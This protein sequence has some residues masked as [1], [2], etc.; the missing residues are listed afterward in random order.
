MPDIICVNNQAG[1]GGI[2]GGQGSQGQASQSASGAGVNS[3]G[4]PVL[5]ITTGM[6]ASFDIQLTQDLQGI[7][8]SDLT[9]IQSIKMVAKPSMQ[10]SNITFQK[11]CT[12]TDATQGK[13]S[14]QLTPTQVN[15]N[16]G[17]HFAQILCYNADQQQ[18]KNYRCYVEIRKGMIGARDQVTYPVTVLDVRLA[19]MDTCA[20]ANHLLDDLEF[21]DMMIID[22]VQRAV[23][24]WNET[25]P[26]ISVM[27]TASNFPWRQ[28]LIKGAVGYLM[29]MVAYRYNRNRMQYS[30][31]GINLDDSD[32]GPNYIAMAQ[33]AK[34][35]W[36]LW[37]MTKKTQCNMQQCFGVLSDP[38]FRNYSPWYS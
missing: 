18:V 37:L 22:S 17:L 19:I 24:Q 34:Q 15:Y 2:A 30:N 8:P 4:Y 23:N 27:Y 3:N 26:Q 21:S 12:I 11:D 25:P 32:K 38:T 6:T 28:H 5:S 14:I 10:S 33:Q 35:Q 7:I 16:Q 1:K 29:Q 9:A 31:S 36:K 13:I 20:E